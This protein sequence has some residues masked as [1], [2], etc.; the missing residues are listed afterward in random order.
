LSQKSKQIKSK[1]KRVRHQ[2]PGAEIPAVL[3]CLVW[4]LGVEKVLCKAV[5][6]TIEPPHNPVSSLSSL[7]FSNLLNM[8]K[9]VV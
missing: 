1:I 9:A 8:D 6:V 7:L 2:I 4:V 5:L 3:S